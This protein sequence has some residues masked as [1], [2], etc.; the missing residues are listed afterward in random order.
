MFDQQI[1]CMRCMFVWTHQ[2]VKIVRAISSSVHFSDKLTCQNTPT[3]DERVHLEAN[4]CNLST[5][6]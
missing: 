1:L 3:H 6:N 4:K 2:H 5:W